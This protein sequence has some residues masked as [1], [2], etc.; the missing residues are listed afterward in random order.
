MT[1]RRLAYGLWR[2]TVSI[3]GVGIDCCQGHRPNACP[4]R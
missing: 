3:A 4:V 2:L 1:R